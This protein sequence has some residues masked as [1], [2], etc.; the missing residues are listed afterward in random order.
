M[1]SALVDVKEVRIFVNFLVDLN[2]TFIDNEIYNLLSTIQPNVYQ[3]ERFGG[4]FYPGLYSNMIVVHLNFKEPE[5]DKVDTR[6]ST[7]DYFANFGGNFGIFVE[8]TGCSFLG[9]LNF[10]IL[11]F[12][13]CFSFKKNIA[14]EK[15]PKE[16]LPK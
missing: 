1:D 14:K 5:V 2:K 9:M 12:K 15:K 8:I 10:S 4:P 7:L 11:M 6:Y 13:L 16:K 3:D